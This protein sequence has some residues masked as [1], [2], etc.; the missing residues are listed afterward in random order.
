[1]A[2]RFSSS[3][4]SQQDS[5]EELTL[6]FEHCVEMTPETPKLSYRDN[7]LSLVE[8]TELS[9]GFMLNECEMAGMGMEEEQTSENASR[10]RVKRKIVK[11]RSQNGRQ[12]GKVS[13]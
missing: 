2:E 8:M 11:R 6:S 9:D 4:C 10:L 5:F 3:S 7:Q 13:L 12:S 1:M